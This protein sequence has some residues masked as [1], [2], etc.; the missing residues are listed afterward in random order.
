MLKDTRPNA[1]IRDLMSSNPEA[2]AEIIKAAGEV[3]RYSWCDRFHRN[4]AVEELHAAFEAAGM[5]VEVLTGGG[6][7]P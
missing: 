6:H 2:C 3:I 1:A 4:R 5:E 7:C